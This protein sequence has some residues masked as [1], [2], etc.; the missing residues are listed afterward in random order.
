VIGEMTSWSSSLTWG[1]NTITGRVTGANW[2]YGEMRHHFA[3]AG[4]RFFNAN[5]EREKR[6]VIFLG[7]ELAR[8]SSATEDPVGKTLFV[9][10]VPYLVIGVLQHKLQMGTYKGPDERLGH[11]HHHLRRPVGPPRLTNIVFKAKTAPS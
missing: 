3:Q 4:G 10:R 1:T 11:P 6:R 9:D 7:D 5:D 2:E 8:T